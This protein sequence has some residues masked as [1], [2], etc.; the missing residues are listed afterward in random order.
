MSMQETSLIQSRRMKS[1]FRLWSP[2][3][4]SNLCQLKL[5]V[6]LEE[7]TAMDPD[8]PP[9]DSLGD[10]VL[11]KQL[12]ELRA[13]V[14]LEEQSTM[15]RQKEQRR[16]AAIE[17]KRRLQERLRQLQQ[18]REAEEQAHRPALPSLPL[19]GHVPSH[20]QHPQMA[21]DIKRSATAVPGH[22]CLSVSEAPV[23]VQE[24][25]QEEQT[26]QRTE[27]MVLFSFMGPSLSESTGEGTPLSRCPP[28][29]GASESTWC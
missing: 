6:L 10:E 16:Q 2:A 12:A 5:L 3:G 1:C 25:H 8:E 13:Q 14:Q 28:D 26:E 20:E 11:Q 4:D 9:L 21:T 15:Q 23:Q 17:E 27:D 22:Q 18:D 24:A 7:N 29:M 19:S